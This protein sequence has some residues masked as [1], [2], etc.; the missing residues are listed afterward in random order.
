M[1]RKNILFTLVTVL[2]VSTT[3]TYASNGISRSNAFVN[4]VKGKE[5]IVEG[6]GNKRTIKVTANDVVKIEGTDNKVTIEGTFA[7]LEVEG[8]SNSVNLIQVKKI[9]VEGTDNK[10]N[11]GNVEIVHVAGTANHVHY[12]SSKNKGGKAD[13]VIE[14]VDNMIMKIK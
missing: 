8:T 9:S 6:T 1:M 13:T 7:K 3:V 11:A 10:I 2:L 14:G 5:I 12:K 4:Q